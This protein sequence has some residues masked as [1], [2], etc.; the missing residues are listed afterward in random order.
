LGVDSKGAECLRSSEKS[1]PASD[2]S[3]N[4]RIATQDDDLA[5]PARVRLL[6]AGIKFK[7]TRPAPHPASPI[8][9]LPH[10]YPVDDRRL[11][12]FIFDLL[13][14][15]ERA[16]IAADELGKLMLDGRGGSR[17]RPRRQGRLIRHAIA[18]YAAI[19]KNYPR[20][21]PKPGFGGPMVRFIRAVADLCGAKV[22]DAAI[23]EVWRSKSKKF[24]LP[25]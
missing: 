25:Q 3:R 23:R 7:T 18:A 8:Q 4:V 1:G 24:W 15:E 6:T 16:Q 19:R 10:V 12:N 14:L 13:W 22:N 9:P 21:G 2:R 11:T 5:V 17:A 20:S